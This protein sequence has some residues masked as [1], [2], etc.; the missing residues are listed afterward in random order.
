MCSS[1]IGSEQIS[2][3]GRSLEEFGGSRSDDGEEAAVGV[4][5]DGVFELKPTSER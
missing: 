1:V 2:Q 3:V 5:E 4:G